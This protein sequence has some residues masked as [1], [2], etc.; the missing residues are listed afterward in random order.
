MWMKS[1]R[2][3]LSSQGRYS[4]KQE[5][6]CLGT[7]GVLLGCPPGLF[8]PPPTL[9]HPGVPTYSY[10]RDCLTL[11]HLSAASTRAVL[12]ELLALQTPAK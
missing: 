8:E 1:C 4:T 5:N 10:H 6:A 3:P 12:D 11:V 7:L 9:Q 2:D